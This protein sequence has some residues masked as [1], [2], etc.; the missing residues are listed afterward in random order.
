[1]AAD[2]QIKAVITADDRASS[3]V[4]GF[5]TSFSKMA[6]AVAAGMAIFEGVKR[7]VGGVIDVFTDSIK[8]FMQA[9]NAQI[10]LK[11]AIQNVT[12]ATNKNINGLLK[13]AGALQKVT[14][15]S[16][17]QIVSAQGI[18]ATFQLNQSAIEKLT[19]RLIDLSEG[20]AR[21]DGTMPDLE[22]N[23]ILV[24]K[25]LGGEDVQGLS[26][27]LRRVGVIMT[28][29]QE[30]V[31]QTGS[32]QERLSIITKILDQ[33]VGGLG[34]VM[35]ETA[36]GKFIQLQN[37]VNDLQEQLGAALFTAIKP[38]IATLTDWARS[39]KAREV[40]KQIS[41]RIVEFGKKAFDFVKTNWEPTIKPALE[42]FASIV[43]GI[44]KGLAAITTAVGV[45]KKYNWEGLKGVMLGPF[46][47]FVKLLEQIDRLLDRIFQ[48]V[49]TGPIDKKTISGINKAAGFPGFAGGVSN[50]SGGMA[51]VGER[52]PEIVNLPRGSD[53]IPNNKIGGSTINLSV[54]VGVYAG[55]ELE[56]RKLAESL[57]ESMKDIASSKN[58]SLNQMMGT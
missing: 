21:V 53:V 37:A 54:N 46:Y 9:E 56:K 50:F 52:G 7:L 38:F 3:V 27:A 12:S 25:A 39:D 2:A 6:G 43:W 4:A 17:D 55:T 15:F 44:A 31:L 10:R 41:D 28:A 8:A 30:K 36:S 40:M 29:Y 1:M 45:L 20:L 19:P 22:G 16:D 57:L 58:Q 42:G 33:N 35:G 51:L 26:G 11:G 34:K 13:Q 23:A 14:R 49:A 32:M 5:G 47:P 48:K 18:L 24:A